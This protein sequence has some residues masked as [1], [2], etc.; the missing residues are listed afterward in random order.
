MSDERHPTDCDIHRRLGFADCGLISWHLDDDPETP[1]LELELLE[2][3]ASVL[4]DQLQRYFDLRP[5][6]AA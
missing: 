5:A 6:S 4:A 3:D 2:L 1:T